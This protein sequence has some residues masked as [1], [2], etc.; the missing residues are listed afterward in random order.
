[1]LSRFLSGDSD[2]RLKLAVFAAGMATFLN[3]YCTMS[4][5]P[6][7][8]K[9]FM[10]SQAATGLTITAPLL[11][12]A[13]VAPLI[14]AISD[15]F[16]RKKLI[17]GAMFLLVIP[18]LLVAGTQHFH[19]MIFWRFVQGLMLPFIFT[20]T[21]AYIGDETEGGATVRLAAV[22][23]SGT[24]FGGFV[25]RAIPGLVAQFYGW[26]VGLLLIAVLTLI[27]AGIVAACLAPER[28]FRPVYGF[29]RALKSFSLH[30]ANK[31][32]LATNAVGFGVLFCMIS[33]FTFINFR[34]AAAPYHLGPAALGC[35]FVVYLGAVVATP[36][37]ARLTNR[38]GRK[39]V[40]LGICPFIAAGLACTM[41]AP[42]PVII[43]GLLLICCAVFVQQTMATS[44]ISTAAA[45]A[46]SAAV[47]L[48]VTCYY[49]GGSTGGILPAP[50]FHHFGWNG[51]VVIVVLVQAVMLGLALRFW[52][53]IGNK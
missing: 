27:L 25:G 48:Y 52:Q 30:L 41:A 15:R 16:G 7:L 12:T 53:P 1:M 10:V 21:I 34:L 29:G 36:F 46:K 17:L 28:R 13:L 26:R 49:I 23:L 50:L 39:R 18:T 9:D 32:L 51:C 43:F 45:Q 19:A 40:M 44:F 2:A 31:R 47:G 35:I 6:L 11:A 4:V 22:Y 20:V 33:V 37:G 3:M 38:F 5:L 14:G 42:L 8:A 24:I